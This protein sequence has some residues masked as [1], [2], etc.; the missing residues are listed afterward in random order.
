MTTE[1]NAV[2]RVA[3]SVAEFCK[4]HGFTKVKF[5]DLLHRGQGPKIMKVGTRTLISIEAATE[6]RRKME[7]GATLST[8][9]RRG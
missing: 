6:W 4:A 7:Q 8:P 5:Y 1:E 9:R 2:P 3:Y